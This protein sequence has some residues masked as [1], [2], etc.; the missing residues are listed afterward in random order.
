MISRSRVAPSDFPDHNINSVNN[1][2]R[3]SVTF[4]GVNEAAFT[5][6][7]RSNGSAR[8]SVAGTSAGATQN[9]DL[10]A[11]IEW[12]RENLA[13][14]AK[15]GKV[16]LKDFKQAARVLDVSPAHKLRPLLM[17]EAIPFMHWLWEYMSI[18]ATHEFG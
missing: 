12:F 16:T 11:C 14:V 18:F 2:R 17:N 9:E 6:H 8:G 1:A 15:Q 5:S 13:K 7:H 3:H 10:S 4:C